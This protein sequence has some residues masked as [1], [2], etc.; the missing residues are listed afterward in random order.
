MQLPEAEAMWR[1]GQIFKSGQAKLFNINSRMR[2]VL[3]VVASTDEGDNKVD[4]FR[5]WENKMIEFVKEMG[6]EIVGI[7]DGLESIDFSRY[8]WI[9]K[10]LGTTSSG[11]RGQL[12]SS[13]EIRNRCIEW[14]YFLLKHLDGLN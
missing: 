12:K 5:F 2:R 7:Q 13:S 6:A 10:A 4:S 11:L 3:V 8:I 14:L 9:L 1:G